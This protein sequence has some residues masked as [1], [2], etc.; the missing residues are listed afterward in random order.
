MP[1]EMLL[2]LCGLRSPLPNYYLS[3]NYLSL[4]AFGRLVSTRELSFKL[5]G[6]RFEPTQ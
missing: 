4:N 6:T 5:L 2:R 3:M 1:L